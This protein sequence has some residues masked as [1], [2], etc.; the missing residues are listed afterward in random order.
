MAALLVAG[1]VLPATAMAH[2]GPHL[3]ESVVMGV[4][5]PIPGVE[6]R[7]IDFDSQVELTNRSGRTVVVEGYEGEPYARIE[8]GGKVYLNA[9]SPSMA[10]SNDRLGRTRPTGA[11]DPDAAPN[12]IL[13]G[14]GGRFRWFDR[15]TQYRRKGLP[16]AVSDETARTR[17]WRWQIPLTIGQ[18]PAVVEGELFW[19]GRRQFPTG[20]F[21]VI[22][23]STAGCGLF[24]AWALRRMREAPDP[25]EPDD[26]TPGS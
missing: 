5:P 2:G 17:V 9:R 14:S 18:S 12:W 26:R 24:G 6:V 25:E 13:V 20:V 15:R 19:L 16:E 10:P 3:Y 21:L 7:M 22:L 11:E 23:F 1:L 4:E 8:S